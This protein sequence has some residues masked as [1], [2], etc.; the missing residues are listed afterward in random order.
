MATD[1]RWWPSWEFRTATLRRQPVTDQSDPSRQQQDAEDQGRNWELLNEEMRLRIDIQ[2]KAFERIEARA[3]I[4]LGATFAA[5]QFVAKESVRSAWLPWAIGAYA[6]AIALSLVAVLPG[7]FVEI[8]PRSILVGLWSY[9][10]SRSAAELANN[11]LVAFEANVERQAR[12]VRLVRASVALA[13]MGAMLST[14]HLTKGERRDGNGRA[15]AV[16][17][18]GAS[19]CGTGP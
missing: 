19:G 11:R 10:R 7:R 9:P 14:A 6:L 17:P 4:V 2:R 1:S 8:R 5:L 15:P 3:A 13:V 16:C 12:I 18:A